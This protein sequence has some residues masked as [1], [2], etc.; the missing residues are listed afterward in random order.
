LPAPPLIF[1]AAS[2]FACTLEQISNSGTAALLAAIVVM[3]SLSTGQNAAF[4]QMVWRPLLWHLALLL[5][6]YLI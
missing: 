4:S 1:T 5:N 3:M 2:A 6:W